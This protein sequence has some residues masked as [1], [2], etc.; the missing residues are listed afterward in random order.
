[1]PG[2]DAGDGSQ[3]MIDAPADAPCATT[4]Y[5]PGNPSPVGSTSC[6]TPTNS[7]MAQYALFDKLDLCACTAGMPT[8]FVHRSGATAIA[9]VVAPPPTDDFSLADNGSSCFGGGAGCV[10]TIGCPN[11]QRLVRTWSGIG[12]VA[13]TNTLVVHNDNGSGC[14]QALYTFRMQL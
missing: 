11:G 9:L 6:A 10:G 3:P 2:D 5:T 7:C 12:V 4:C 8:L 14:T 13:G 1:M